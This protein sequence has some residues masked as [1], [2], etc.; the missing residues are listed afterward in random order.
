MGSVPLTRAP[1]W[2]S[3]R[4]EEDV[5]REGAAE[6][7]EEE[8]ALSSRAPMV[9]SIWR[10]S[11]GSRPSFLVVIS[12]GGSDAFSTTS[13]EHLHFW[14]AFWAWSLIFMERRLLLRMHARLGD[15][16]LAQHFRVQY[17]VEKTTHPPYVQREQSSQRANIFSYFLKPA[18]WANNCKRWMLSIWTRTSRQGRI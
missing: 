11:L 7:V 6:E 10:L 2:P 14:S 16:A 3:R 18:A 1:C 15:R 12:D 9:G 8:E 5:A 4:C 17:R 13:M